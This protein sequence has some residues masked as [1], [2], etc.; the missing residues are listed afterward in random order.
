MLDPEANAAEPTENDGGT[1]AALR[2]VPLADAPLAADDPDVAAAAAEPAE[3]DG[4]TK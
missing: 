2:S 4:G 3:N 1:K